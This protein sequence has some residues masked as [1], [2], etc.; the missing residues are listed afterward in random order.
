M[1]TPE[2]LRD[3]VDQDAFAALGA[4]VAV[5]AAYGL[6]LPRRVLDAPRLG[7]INVHASLLPRWRGAAPI[8][9]AILAGVEPDPNERPQ[10][11]MDAVFDSVS[12]AT[13]FKATLAKAG[14]IFCQRVYFLQNDD[15]SQH[16]VQ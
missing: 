10:V 4:D 5:V 8:Q 11:A 16:L 15:H 12:V 7:C 14:V 1:H 2:R 9:R 3:P 6:I 13:T